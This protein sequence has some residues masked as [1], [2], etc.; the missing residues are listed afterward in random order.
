[1]R[2]ALC[3]AEAAERAGE[4]PVGAVVV[5]GG[6]IIAR[7]HNQPIAANDPTAHAEIVALR[8]A[9]KALSNYRLTDAELVVTVEPCVM[10]VGAIVHARVRRV[11]YGCA[12]AKAGALGSV[13]D[14]S[15]QPGLNHHF[16]VTGGVLAD[17][18]RALLQGFF[19]RRRLDGSP[20][21]A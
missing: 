1:M 4:V 8:A 15:R 6:R 17:E 5:A 21:V 10:C 16:T 12:D 11:V 18:S 7:G 19:R 2:A 3:E 20:L 9:G 14:L 13:L